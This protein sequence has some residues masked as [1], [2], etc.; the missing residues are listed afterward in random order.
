MSCGF[1][2][3]PHL[4][5]T[6]PSVFLD[7]KLFSQ[8][9]PTKMTSKKKPSKLKNVEVPTC[10]SKDFNREFRSNLTYFQNNLFR[11]N[12][13]KLFERNK[14]CFFFLVKATIIYN[15]IVTMILYSTVIF[16]TR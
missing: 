5:I 7:L 12:F 3:F 15:L 4:Q 10:Y 16:G 9:I 2:L 13:K 14:M 8:N 1:S 6:F 11:A